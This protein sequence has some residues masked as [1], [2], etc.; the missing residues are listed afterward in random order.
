MRMTFPLLLALPCLLLI[1][2]RKE[3]VDNATVIKNCTG[4]YLQIDG[5]N[6]QVCNDTKLD[7]Y[8]QGDLVDASFKHINDCDALAGHTIC[9]MAFPSEGWIEVRRVK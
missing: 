1:S 6:Y 4:T 7:A 9:H 2:C 8:K 3:K 5:D